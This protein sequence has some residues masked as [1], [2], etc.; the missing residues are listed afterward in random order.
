M[1]PRVMAGPLRVEVVAREVPRLRRV[2]VDAALQHPNP[3]KSL[4][5]DCLRRQPPEGEEI[6]NKKSGREKLAADYAD[7]TDSE[8]NQAIVLFPIRVIRVI[9]G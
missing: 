6:N 2:V 5:S 4:L 8:Q 9:R 3:M 1:A 7:Y